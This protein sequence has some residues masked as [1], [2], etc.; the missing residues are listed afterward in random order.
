MRCVRPESVVSQSLT[1]FTLGL[2]SILHSCSMAPVNLLVFRDTARQTQGTVAFKHVQTMVERITSCNRNMVLDALVTAGAFESALNDLQW[3]SVHAAIGLTDALAAA[4][5]HPGTDPASAIQKFLS[6]LANSAMPPSVRMNVPEGFAYY[7]LHPL[8]FGEC[9]ITG[10]RGDTFAVVGIRSIGTV[11]SAVLAASIGAQGT[12]VARR[13]VRPTGHPYDRVLQFNDL[14]TAWV[15]A[16]KQRGSTFVIVDEG[17]GLSGSSFLATAEALANLGVPRDCILM[18][19]THPVDPQQLCSRDAVARWQ[20]FNWRH[21]DSTLSRRFAALAPMGAGEW[22]RTAFCF[23]DEWPACWPEMERLKFLSKDGR[24]LLKFDGFGSFGES[25]RD[26]GELAFRSGFGPQLEDAGDGMTAYRLIPG[27]PLHP[28]DVSESR[29]ARVADYCAFRASEFKVQPRTGGELE[30]MVRFNFTQEFG[31]EPNFPEG[32]LNPACA[33]IADGHMQPHEW[34]P[35][36]RTVLKL[37]GATHGDDHFYPGPTDIAWDLAGTFI[38][39]N[40]D[41]N[42]SDVLL[43]R[44]RDRSGVRADAQLPWFLLAYATF[45]MAYCKMAMSATHAFQE[46]KRLENVYRYYRNKARQFSRC[47]SARPNYP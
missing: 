39:W 25:V 10:K 32:S 30:S 3:P 12:S 14:E 45:R 8:D 7:A 15:N 11:L 34:I 5:F 28:E 35:Y 46:K 9:A 17:P 37:D 18:S 21:V 41:A 4:L 23:Q 47:A 16:H 31:E 33:V 40:L 43:R 20:R 13:T 19:G 26:R 22:R 2:C 36:D 1:T 27:R 24:Q 42:Q 29:L 44:F 38:E 6:E